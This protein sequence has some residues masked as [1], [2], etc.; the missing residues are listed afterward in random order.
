MDHRTI[1]HKRGAS[2]EMQVAWTEDGAPLS[3]TGCVISSQARLPDGTLVAN[4]E[5]KS[6]NDAAGVVVLAPTAEY[7]TAGWPLKTINID[8]R[9][10][11]P[12]GGIVFTDTVVVQVVRQETQ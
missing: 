8:V 6:R 11:Q 12:D 7:P 2:F 1:Q 5:V 10:E 3:I 9:M 4:F